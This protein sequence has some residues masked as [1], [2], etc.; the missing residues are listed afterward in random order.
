MAS[1]D[2]INAASKG[3]EF[4]WCE[5]KY[6]TRVVIPVFFV[7]LACL[8]AVFAIG[9][10]D[11]YLRQ[12]LISMP[13]FVV[14]AIFIIGLIRYFLYK[15]PIFI[16]GKLVPPPLS[17]VKQAAYNGF[18]SKKQ[19]MQGAIALYLLMR[20][21]EVFLLGITMDN[22]PDSPAVALPEED[23]VKLSPAMTSLIMF[24]FLIIFTWSFKLFWLFIP[25][26]SGYPIS[27]Y[28]KKMPGLR[29]SVGML[30]TWILCSLPLMTL[31]SAVL[32]LVAGDG[33]E[34]GAINII[35]TSV[36]KIM[37]EIVIISVQVT[38][39]TYGINKILSGKE[40]SQ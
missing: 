6:L 5:R 38:A 1:F 30:A 33:A 2:F 26:A 28:L 18:M 24:S 21:T 29:G 14:E 8:F 32:Q 3:Y 27:Y 7:K 23:I 9:A 4:I 31:F 36:I 10:Q 35:L 34:D 39:M 25:T 19:C 13:G 16:W 15:E 20:V 17:D 22:M 40:N 11:N 37:S 12:G